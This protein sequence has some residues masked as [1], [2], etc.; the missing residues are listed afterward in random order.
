M[1]AA[2]PAAA[3]DKT[4]LCLPLSGN[5]TKPDGSDESLSGHP[6]FRRRFVCRRVEHHPDLFIDSTNA[7]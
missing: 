5:V 4:P 6:S 1:D 2:K 7:F 3:S